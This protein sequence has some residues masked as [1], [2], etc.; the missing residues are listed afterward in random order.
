MQDLPDEEDH[1]HKACHQAE[2]ALLAL[3][4]NLVHHQVEAALQALAILM[5]VNN[6][7]S[8]SQD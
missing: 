1:H 6:Q 7:V 5:V 8:S 3:D 4:F 2:V